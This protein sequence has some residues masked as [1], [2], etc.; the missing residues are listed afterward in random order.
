MNE[1]KIYFI[2]SIVKQ[3]NE[4]CHTIKIRSEMNMYLFKRF[5]QILGFITCLVFSLEGFSTER[6]VSIN[7]PA[8]N[9]FQPI[10]LTAKQINSLKGVDVDAVRVYKNNNGNLI[11]IPFQVDQRDEKQ[12]Y[13][14]E[15]SD[16]VDEGGN[17]LVFD[18]NDELVFMLDDAGKNPYEYL[19]KDKHLIEV[20]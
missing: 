11:P 14:L 19:E 12:R 18:E 16:S 20:Q 3:L 8:A 5:Y 10:I 7:Y 17:R 2:K 4:G 13:V 9:S 6:I 1:G 15:E